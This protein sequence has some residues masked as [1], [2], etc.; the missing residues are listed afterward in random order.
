MI[1]SNAAFQALHAV[2]NGAVFD[3]PSSPI[4]P[5]PAEEIDEQPVVS[6]NKAKGF[7]TTSEKR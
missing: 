1:P 7:A 6:T 5:S 4:E 2:I 3:A